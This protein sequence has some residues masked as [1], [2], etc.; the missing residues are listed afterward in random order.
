MAVRRANHYTKQVVEKVY[1]QVFIHKN[2]IC[3]TQ[4]CEQL[5]C[6]Q[7]WD[8]ST[9][10]MPLLSAS[11]NSNN[12]NNKLWV[13]KAMGSHYTY[14]IPGKTAAWVPEFAV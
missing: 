1:M 7:A 4:R 6:Q 10:R 3:P 14:S 9:T 12:N 8:V 13:R 2:I 5:E 11:S